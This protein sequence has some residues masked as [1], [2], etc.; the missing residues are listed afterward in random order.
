MLTDHEKILLKDFSTDEAWQ[1]VE[2]LSTLDKTSGTDG[3]R[4]A[5]EYVQS[6][7]KKYG[8]QFEEYVF[9]SYI[10]HPKEASL[11]ILSGDLANIEC[12]THAF[13]PN[14]DVNGVEGE[15]VFV[16]LPPGTLFGGMEGL[17]DEYKKVGAEGKI[18]V[19]WGLPGPT[20]VWA[21]ELA[22]AKGQIHIS[23]ENVLHEMIV[24]TIWGTPTSDSSKRLPKIPTVSIKRSDGEKILKMM[25]SQKIIVKINARVDTKWRKIPITVAKIPGT[26]NQEKFMLVHGHMDSWYVGTTDNCTGNAAC[27][28]LARV[29][30][31]NKEKLKRGVRFAWWSGH[32][33]GR[34]SGSTWYADNFFEDLDKNCY[35]TMNI[36]SPGVK[37]SSEVGGGGLM[38]TTDYVAEAIKDVLEISKI[39]T[40]VNAMRAGDQSFYNLGLPSVS[41]GSHIPQGT[42][43]TGVWIGGSGGGWWWHSAFDTVDKGD[44]DNLIRDIK[45]ESMLIYRAANSELLPFDF[46]KVA[47]DIEN[48]LQQIQ[49]RVTSGTFNL[50]TVFNRII[51]LNELSEQINKMK[52]ELINQADKKRLDEINEILMRTSKI[53]TALLYTYEEKY[54]QDPAYNMG[55]IPPLQQVGDLAK[56]DPESDEYSFLKT[57]LIRQINRVNDR[58]DYVNKI[59]GKIALQ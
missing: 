31:K 23:G 12:I 36:D 59:L 27:L 28:E 47:K 11:K 5:H 41:V 20:V 54:E 21:A 15:L 46:N 52:P 29:F 3:E 38:G 19:V 16:K 24:T 39:Q 33:T 56:L 49:T 45:L 10:S 9:N 30:N 4:K 43:H 13:S 57:K 34:Y 1:H 25:E 35:L 53:L 48:A 55:L 22:G 2:F 14:T 44:K 32:S 26:E 7:L 6:C 42:P 50:N 8:V 18:A 17:V 40:R 58:L 37:F 51:K